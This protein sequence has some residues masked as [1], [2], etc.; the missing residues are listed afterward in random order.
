MIRKLADLLEETGLTELE[1]EVGDRRVKVSRAATGG[2][3]VAAWPAAAPAP[4]AA[5]V[6]AASGDGPTP[7]AVTAPMV[8]TIFLSPEPGAPPF[9]KI[10]DRVAEGDTLFLIEAMKT[11]NPVKAPR[12]GTVGQILVADGSPVE[13]GEELMTVE[14]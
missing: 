13:F 9:V 8:G 6:G 2:S 14:P 3:Q 12:A 1:V 11:Y 4:Q 10:G 7:N 5:A